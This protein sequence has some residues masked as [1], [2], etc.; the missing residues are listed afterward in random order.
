[1]PGVMEDRWD[2]CKS[3][4]RHQLASEDALA[5]L[6]ALRLNGLQPGRIDL[7]GIPN[8]FF[9]NRIASRYREVI[10]EAVRRAFPDIPFQ[11]APT[12]ALRVEPP[13][14]GAPPADGSGEGA[15]RTAHGQDES[16]AAAAPQEEEEP[17]GSAAR[18]SPWHTFANFHGAGE[19]GAAL[20]LAQQAAGQPG[21]A[22]NPFLLVGATGTGKSHLLQALGNALRQERPRRVIYRT[23]EEFK[24]EVLDGI[25]RRR[26][27]QF[28]EFYRAADALLIDDL[29]FL[30]VSPRAQEELLHTL[31]GLHRAGRQLALSC[32]R[33]PRDLPALS[34]ALCSRLEMGLVAELAPPGPEIRRRVALARAAR[35]GIDLPEAVAALLAARITRSLRQ[36]EGAVVRLGAYSGVYREAITPAFAAHIAAPFFDPEEGSNGIPVSREQILERVADRFGVTVRSLKGRGRSPHLLAARRVAVHLLKTKG[37]CSYPEIG[38]LLGNRAHSTMVHSHQALLRDMAHN[39]HLKQQVMKLTRAMTG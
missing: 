13:P 28:R 19:N 21:G 37:D 10:V 23:G 34:E 24:N 5:W 31:D 33:F 39:P 16:P 18:L 1:M 7:G 15:A 20:R 6:P 38:A 11:E 35:D 26:M 2:H 27:R 8:S 22:F 30:L 3:R 12:L 25:T 36:L 4:I 29:Q 9:K 17:R 32:D 14:D